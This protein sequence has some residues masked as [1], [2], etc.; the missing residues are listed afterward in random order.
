MKY[1]VEV[2]N[3]SKIAG[4]REWTREFAKIRNAFIAKLRARMEDHEITECRTCDERGKEEPKYFDDVCDFLGHMIDDGIK[5]AYAICDQEG[6]SILWVCSSDELPMK[7]IWP[8]GNKQIICQDSHHGVTAVKRT[9]RGLPVDERFIVEAE[10]Q[11]SVTFPESYKC[12]MMSANGGPIKIKR[13]H[14]MLYPI[15]DKTDRKSI[16][17]TAESIQ[18]ESPRSSKLSDFPPDAQDRRRRWSLRQRG[19]LVVLQ[20]GQ[21]SKSCRGRHRTR[22]VK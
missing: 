17:R 14:Y 19:L 11:L 10:E 21:T 9:K 3:P 12:R 16:R 22:R 15:F 4:K 8:C 2:S 1:Q 13:S 5:V 20:N 6:Q 18:V 7:P